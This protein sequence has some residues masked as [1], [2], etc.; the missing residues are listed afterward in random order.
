MHNKRNQLKHS[1]SYMGQNVNKIYI[2]GYLGV[3]GGWRRGGQQSS[4]PYIYIYIDI[5]GI[6][7]HIYMS[8][9][10]AI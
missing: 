1:F 3:P 2:F 10:E 8:N 4:H 6:Y 7:V 5:Y 9:M